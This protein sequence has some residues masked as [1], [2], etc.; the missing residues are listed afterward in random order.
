MSDAIA[1]MPKHLTQTWD[2]VKMQGVNMLFSFGISI[3]N[4]SLDDVS[5]IFGF[6]LTDYCLQYHGSRGP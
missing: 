4:I 3:V 2:Y 5:A 6:N 1:I